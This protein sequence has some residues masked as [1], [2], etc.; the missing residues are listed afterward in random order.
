MVVKSGKRTRIL[1]CSE[2]EWIEGAGVY[3]TLHLQDSKQILHRSSLVELEGKLDPNLFVR[4]HRSAIVNI[5][6]ISHLEPMTH[7]EFEVAMRSGV[8]VK[9]SRSY[10]T[11]LE[12]RLRQAL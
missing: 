12:K 2:I 3:V 7:G 11:P 4:I 6:A 9:L 10:R 8:R 1:K 5:E